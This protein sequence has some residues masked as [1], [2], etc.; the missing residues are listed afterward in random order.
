MNYPKTILNLIECFKKYPGIGEKTAERLALASINMDSDIV[1]LFSKSLKDGKT[2]IKKCSRCGSLTEDDLCQICTDKSRDTSTLC[3]VEECKNVI[4][5]EKIGSYKGIYHVL[6][7][8][9]SPL[10][11]I[12]PEDIHI[13]KLIDRIKNENIKE[14]ILA[15]KPSVEGETTALYIRKM[16]EGTDVKISKIAHGIPMGADIDY[17]DPLTLEMAIEDRTTIS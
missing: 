1:D 14:V 3:V 16:L 9:I 4:L 11:G 17:I 2:K 5:F 12:N 10:E 7:G 8:L 15:I 13:D 6:G